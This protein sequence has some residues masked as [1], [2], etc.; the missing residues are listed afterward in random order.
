MDQPARS[1]WEEAQFNVV[2]DLAGSKVILSVFFIPPPPPTLEA[3][4]NNIA[5]FTVGSAQSVSSSSVYAGLEV[6]HLPA[7]AR[8]S[9]QLLLLNVPA[10]IITI[11]LLRY[12]L[13]LCASMCK[14]IVVQSLHP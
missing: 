8:G 2:A 10:T 7:A 5:S 14:M 4:Q 1:T 12:I 6:K 3:E 9:V 13:Y 11:D